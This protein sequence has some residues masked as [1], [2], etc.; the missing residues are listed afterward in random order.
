MSSNRLIYDECAYATQMKESVSPLEYNLFAGKYENCKQC[1]EG[2][3]TNLLE[4]GVKTDDEN[5]LL[6]LTRQNTKCPGNKYNPE[7]KYNNANFSAARMCESI[8]NITP[9]NVEK[10]TSNM[11]NEK[12][13]GV[14]YCPKK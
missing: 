8:Y 4:F 14:N 7:V 9:S 3:Y 12:N 6:G 1:S 2:E 10:P 5:E 13:L 11:L